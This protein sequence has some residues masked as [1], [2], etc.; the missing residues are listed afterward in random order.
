MQMRPPCFGSIEV[1]RPEYQNG[2]VIDGR[3]GTETRRNESEP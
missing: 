2:F 3:P 1:D